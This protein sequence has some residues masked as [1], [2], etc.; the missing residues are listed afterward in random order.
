MRNCICN[1]QDLQHAFA[2]LQVH[3]HQEGQ[4]E[5][6]LHVGTADQIDNTKLFLPVRPTNKTSVYTCLRFKRGEE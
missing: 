4:L 5:S 6:E 1:R 3:I 2:A